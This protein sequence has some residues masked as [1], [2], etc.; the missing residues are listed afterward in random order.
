MSHFCV[1]ISTFGDYGFSGQISGGH[2]YQCIHIS[3]TGWNK[4]T[5]FPVGIAEHNR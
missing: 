1:I 4:A 3:V 2:A 5:P